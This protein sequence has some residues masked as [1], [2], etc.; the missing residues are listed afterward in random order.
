[1]KV[2]FILAVL[3]FF[4]QVQVE[5]NT[6]ITCSNDDACPTNSHC[7]RTRCE[8]ESK[9]AN[10]HC[11]E[12]DPCCYKKKSFLAPLILQAIPLT[13]PL[14]IGFFIIDR[15]SIGV[16]MLFLITGG[17]CV[18][19][20]CMSCLF[21]KCDLDCLSLCVYVVVA[22]MGLVNVALWIWSIVVFA[23]CSIKDGNG[24]DLYCY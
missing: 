22:L 21:K 17:F 18:L 3:F 1:M 7:I 24:V 9:Y 20:C 11:E 12:D 5:S 14:G 10:F 16:W 4:L 15:I 6:N 19:P 2:Y 13:G 23:N 8:C